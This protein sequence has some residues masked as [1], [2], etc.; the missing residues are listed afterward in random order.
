MHKLCSKIG[1]TK[2]RLYD[3]ARQGIEVER[4]EREVEIFDIELLNFTNDT[5]EF[6]V[7]CSKGTY[8]IGK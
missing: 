3:L 5:I 7:N 2:K 4:K 1:Y 8:D 6:K